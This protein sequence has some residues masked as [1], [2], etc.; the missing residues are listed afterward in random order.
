MRAPRKHEGLTGS[1]RIG[2]AVKL[3]AAAIVPVSLAISPLASGA[4]ARPHKQSLL[5]QGQAYFK[6]KTLTFVSPDGA[7]SNF[8]ILA[9]LIA[10]DLGQELGA[11]VQVED[12]T[13]G[14]G[15]TAFNT[16][17]FSSPNGLTLGWLNPAVALEDILEGSPGINFDPG[18]EAMLAGVPGPDSFLCVAPSTGIKT[19]AQLLQQAT[20]GSLKVLSPSSGSAYFS[21]HIFPIAFGMKF[22]E[23]SAYSGSSAAQTGFLRGDGQVYYSSGASL[24][25][26]VQA[27]Q[28]NLLATTTPE[29]KNNLYYKVSTG[30][31]VPYFTT[32][33]PA[34]GG[35]KPPAHTKSLFATYPGKNNTQ[36][37][38]LESLELWITGSTDI[39][40]TGS[41]VPADEVAALQWA[42]QKVLT[43]P[44]YQTQELATGSAVGYSSGRSAKTIWLNAIHKLGTGLRLIGLCP[45]SGCTG[46]PA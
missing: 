33:S 13:T 16:I 24:G 22:Q 4:A 45:A 11:T 46:K 18:K 23:I 32:I 36:R 21:T 34:N 43:S 39:I 6:G 3:L 14:N 25:P 28:C 29:P 40:Y 26:V 9:R 1:R 17:A 15:V 31:G 5:S 27:G 42:M 7:G 37:A 12:L 2:R 10:P 20:S 41:A 8:D 44:S 19:F 30:A 35:V 38:A